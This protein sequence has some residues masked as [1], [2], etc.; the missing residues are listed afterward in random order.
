MKDC[1]SLS[2]NRR[3]SA[4][5]FTIVTPRN[6]RVSRIARY[7][8]AIFVGILLFTAGCV[9][10]QG[11]GFHSS[12]LTSSL[13]AH[14]RYGAQL[15]DGT[16]HPTVPSTVV[17]WIVDP[18]S[19]ASPAMSSAAR[20]RTIVPHSTKQ[21]TLYDVPVS[22]HGAR[23]RMLIYAKSL[24]NQICIDSPQVLGGLK[25]E[26]FRKLNPMAKMP[27]MVLED[28]T[29][30]PES[31][32][33][34]RYLE[35]KF[36]QP[37]FTPPDLDA[38]TRSDLFAHVV[39]AY[40]SPIQG[41]MYRGPMDAATRAEQVKSVATYLNFLEH[42]L[43]DSEAPASGT[44]YAKGPFCAGDKPSIGDIIAYPT[45][46]FAEYILPKKFGWSDIFSQRP[47]LRRW[48]EAMDA[49]EPAGQ[50]KTEIRDA[51]HKWDQDGR[52]E[53]VG[54]AEQVKDVNSLTWAH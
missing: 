6:L 50:V 21:M 51:L 34:V 33:I 10:R 3:L 18:V 45:I 29:A 22:N 31:T 54:I 30:L 13:S 2:S 43:S 49:W 9:A 15:N 32:V 52:W 16:A 25:S 35:S 28:G 24:E 41:C 23:V 36:P 5:I 46:V 27:I 39:D 26:E 48:W 17:P 14:I 12:N 37:S 8:L 11:S 4:R 20:R 38:R 47:G 53:R 19:P 42:I 40:I 1:V 7:A 44:P